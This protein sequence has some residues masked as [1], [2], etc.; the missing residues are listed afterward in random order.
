MPGVGKRRRRSTGTWQQPNW[1]NVLT[2]LDFQTIITMGDFNVTDFCLGAA[3]D[4]S[5]AVCAVN[6]SLS[7]AK[8]GLDSFFLLFG[9][10]LFSWLKQS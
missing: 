7:S 1:L 10:R 4:T 5:S 8:T 9:V 6:D 3:D 2:K